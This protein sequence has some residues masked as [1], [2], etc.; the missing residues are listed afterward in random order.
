MIQQVNTWPVTLDRESIHVPVL[1]RPDLTSYGILQITEIAA[2]G[3][4]PNSVVQH[5]LNRPMRIHVGGTMLVRHSKMNS[6]N[7]NKR[8][9]RS[10][11]SSA[12]KHA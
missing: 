6:I 10:H 9:S 12:D 4:L 7:T 3:F 1:W 8:S 5:R 2:I 11:A